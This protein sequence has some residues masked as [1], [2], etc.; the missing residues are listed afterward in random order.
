MLQLGYPFAHAC[1]YT[2]IHIESECRSL[3]TTTTCLL[4]QL[5]YIHIAYCI[6]IYWFIGQFSLNLLINQCTNWVLITPTNQQQCIYWMLQYIFVQYNGM[7]EKYINKNINEERCEKAIKCFVVVN[8]TLI[9]NTKSYVTCS[10][11][12]GH[13]CSQLTQ[14]HPCC[15]SASNK[16][17]ELYEY[18]FVSPFQLLTCFI[19]EFVAHTSR[20]A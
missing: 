8:C 14:L 20:L 10:S 16:R 6:Y 1:E 4:Q 3:N 7:K 18:I 12:N 9:N 5:R 15:C 2:I 11:P 19:A 17:K 13:L